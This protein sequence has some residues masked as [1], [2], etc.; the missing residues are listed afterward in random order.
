MAAFIVL[1]DNPTRNNH[2]VKLVLWFFPVFLEITAHFAV[3][4]LT[5]GKTALSVKYDSKTFRDRS[6]TVFIIILGAGLDNITQGFHFM[7]GNLSFGPHR[8]GVI[9]C[10][11]VIFILL[12]TLHFTTIPDR[13][14]ADV[15]DE[16]VRR[17]RDL[18]LFF[19]GFF[20]LSAVIITLQGMD[21]MMQ[22]GVSVSLMF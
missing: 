7:V 6:A 8:I 9:F 5:D 18:G 15:R 21:A 10:A 19:F 17:R 2:I 14:R 1:G 11:S 3:S 16:G 22:V 13:N 20:Y 4:Y 12:F